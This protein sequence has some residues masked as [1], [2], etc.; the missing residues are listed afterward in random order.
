M[1]EAYRRTGDGFSSG[2]DNLWSLQAISQPYILS[3]SARSRLAYQIGSFSGW[4][5]LSISTTTCHYCDFCEYHIP[6]IHH[7]TN[8]N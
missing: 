5:Q 1:T 3:D 6:L 4:R 2:V 7:A 8:F